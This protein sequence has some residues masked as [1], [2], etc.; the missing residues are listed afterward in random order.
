M[1]EYQ[2]ELISQ[3]VDIFAQKANITNQDVVHDMTIRLCSMN[4]NDSIDAILVSLNDLLRRKLITLE[5]IFANVDT[6]L[7]LNPDKYQSVNDLIN[8]LHWIQGMNIEHPDMTLAE[9]HQLVLTVFDKFNELIQDRF[10]C[11]YT[12]GLMGYL[13]TNHELERY[14][15]DLDLFVNENQLIELKELI[16]SSSDF[17]F[18]S[19]MNHKEVNGHEYKIV[20]KGTPMS[21]GLFLFERLPD[22][23]IT[24]KEYYFENQD[25]YGPLFVDEHHFS[26]SFTDM[27]FSNR[28]R[29][30]NGILYRM[31]SLESIYNS[32]KNAR[33]KDR[34]D[35]NVIKEDVDMMVDYQLDV[36]KKNNFSVKHKKVTHTIIHKI[37]SMIQESKEDG[38][39]D[40]LAKMN[41]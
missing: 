1:N 15:G 36:E 4:I 3:L 5:D 2:K 8:R 17:E 41:K 13:A 11:Y 9:N 21:I 31:M 26:K 25:T 40:I 30:H 34:Y 10:D 39:T 18:V 33:F 27:S 16:D 38:T 35:A 22:Y 6:I 19:N 29:Y 23:S 20:Y 37:E 28:V 14:H 12:G 24:T 32:K 7:K